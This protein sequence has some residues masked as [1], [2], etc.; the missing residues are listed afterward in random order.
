MRGRDT[1]TAV[2]PSTG[3]SQS[4]SRNGVVIM[5]EAR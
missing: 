5:R 4:N 1:T 2:E 3:A